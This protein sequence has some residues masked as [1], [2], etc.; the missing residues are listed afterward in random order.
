MSNKKYRPGGTPSQR[1][2][3]SI[4]EELLKQFV[5]ESEAPQAPSDMDADPMPD[6]LAR[7]MMANTAMLMHHVANLC[8][9]AMDYC[10][11]GQADLLFKQE[12]RRELSERHEG[13]KERIRPARPHA[14]ESLMRIAL[15]AVRLMHTL[16]RATNPKLFETSP[17][18][19]LERE[20]AKAI[21]EAREMNEEIRARYQT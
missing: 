20:A 13:M 5:N 9:N 18:A 8:G 10:D 12:V 7:R 14:F 19:S 17:S 21:N 2:Q 3:N 11:P 4:P 6:K 15:K 1:E 16:L